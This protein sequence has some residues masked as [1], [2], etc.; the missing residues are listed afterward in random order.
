MEE[1][2]RN[3]LIVLAF[4]AVGAGFYYVVLPMYY[5][6]GDLKSKIESNVE[7]IQ[8]AQTQAA[9]LEGLV[10]DLKKT[11]KDLKKAKQKLP[12]KGKFRELMTA[13]ESQ[14]RQAG[15]PDRKILEFSQGNVTTI[16]EGLVEEM[17]ISARFDSI[18]MQQLVD[19][20]WRFDNMIRMLDIKSFRSFNLQR[21]Q[22]DDQFFYNVNMNMTVYILRDTDTTEDS[23]GEQA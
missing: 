14:A 16:K 2:E 17:V 19:M 13:L 9:Q 5:E 3:L 20:L 8:S 12:D 22:M 21:V 6:Y 11:K 15:I 23:D 7:E 18:S 4:A 1:R 10:E